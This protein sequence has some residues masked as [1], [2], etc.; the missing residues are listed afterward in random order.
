MQAVAPIRSCFRQ[1]DAVPQVEIC[2]PLT[3][4]MVVDRGAGDMIER[5]K[6]QR[7]RYRA[8]ASFPANDHSGNLILSDRRRVPTRRAFDA[9]VAE[10][11]FYYKLD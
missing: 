9:A 3:T 1:A 10:N 8:H 2:R 7:R 11:R 4:L 5:R 6:I